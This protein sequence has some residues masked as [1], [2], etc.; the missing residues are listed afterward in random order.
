MG[1]GLRSEGI[2]DKHECSPAQS[3]DCP[4]PI[5]RVLII[6]LS[7][8]SAPSISPVQMWVGVRGGQ[9]TK[10]SAIRFVALPISRNAHAELRQVWTTRSIIHNHRKIRYR[11][12]D[13]T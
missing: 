7:L 8:P 11:L 10:S 12:L 13:S 4:R 3:S 2:D 5:Y 9:A 1:E 6:C